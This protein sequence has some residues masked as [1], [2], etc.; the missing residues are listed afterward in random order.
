MI[1]V[2][3]VYKNISE[4]AD[5][6]TIRIISI[7]EEENLFYYVELYSNVV[8]PYSYVIT[9]F[10]EEIKQGLV[11]KIKD[12]Y[13]KRIEEGDLPLKARTKRDLD[14]EII[15]TYWIEAKIDLLN[16][17]TRG[18]KYIEIA[19]KTGLSVMK[20]KRLFTR[21]WQR[22]M[23]KNAMLLDYSNSGA[24]GKARTLTENKVGRPQKVDY[25]GNKR[26]G[27]NSTPEIRTIFEAGI[28]RY[29]RKKNKA[30]LKEVYHF[31]LRDF[32]SDKYIEAG[33]TKYNVWDKEYIPTYQQF[34]YWFKKQDKPMKT[35]I[36]RQ[37]IKEYELKYR[38]L[39]GNSTNETIG[40]GTRFQVD[41]TIADIY[42]VSKLNRN[43]IIGRPIVYAII[44]VFSRMI[45]GIYVGLEGPSWLGAM[46][47]LENMVCD[48]VSFCKIY[49]IEIEEDQWPAKH[50]P[51]TIIA[52][53][54]EFEGYSPEN[55]IN[56][57][58][59]AIENTP[60]YR[61]DLKGIVERSFN[62]LN[63]RLKHQTPGAIMK[64]FRS[65]GDKDYRLDAT[66]TLEEFTKAYIQLVIHHNNTLVEHY[67]LQKEMLVEGIM[68]IPT[69]LWQWGIENKKGTL[70]T[71]DRETMRLNVLPKAKANVSRAGIKF[72]NL[73]Y[74][75]QKALE[76]Q[77][78]INK[79]VRSIEIVYDPRNMDYIYI[80]DEDG[81]SYETCYLLEASKQYNSI[82]LEELIFAQELQSECIQNEK[83]AQVQKNVDVNQEI[84]AIIKQAK[85]EKTKVKCIQQQSKTQ[86]LKN[87]KKNRTVEKEVNRVSESFQLNEDNKQTDTKTIELEHVQNKKLETEQTSYKDKLMEKLRK[88]RDEHYGEY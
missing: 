37:G 31:I 27:I 85:K 3:E 29:Y 44:D 45:V 10:L 78:F 7:F 56:N 2:N 22:G 32:F 51:E 52:D 11:L 33:E 19:N 1:Y 40:P 80:P 53:R 13:L 69:K 39:L 9:T 14:W 23:N 12:P 61:G 73:L 6:N 5:G 79:S 46:M 24:R 41:A 82:L 62:T 60:P 36:E 76:E 63:T 34:Y 4:Q 47:A 88:K 75:S 57:L 50:L 48:K 20:V 58:G 64:E 72:K 21:F 67:P 28:N 17:A 15:N 54:G 68:P 66:L 49:G 35:I 55:L 70:R 16:K 81:R 30:S 42:L 87:I 65:R 38:P 8:T 84:E 77:W 43:R 74:G 83:Q 26:V 59:I 25:Q 86:K 71:I 18:N